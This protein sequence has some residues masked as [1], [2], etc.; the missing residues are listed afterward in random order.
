MRVN[1]IIE[2][3]RAIEFVSWGVFIC[4]IPSL[5]LFR[6]LTISL[7]F[8]LQHIWMNIHIYWLHA[9]SGPRL[10]SKKK[11]ILKD[12]SWKEQFILILFLIQT[13][14]IHEIFY[15]KSITLLICEM[16]DEWQ[17][18]NQG[19]PWSSFIFISFID[20]NSHPIIFYC[21]KIYYYFV[22]FGAFYWLKDCVGYCVVE[23]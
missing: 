4:S 18:Y 14:S 10:C 5:F 22:C 13:K 15:S 23:L 21:R 20:K 6:L 1:W 17:I 11:K 16:H 2:E 3:H 7:L 19:Q 8:L 12:F 9:F